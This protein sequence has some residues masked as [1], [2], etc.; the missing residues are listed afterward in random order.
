MM[1]CQRDLYPFDPVILSKAF[2]YVLKYF[3]TPQ[4]GAKAPQSKIRAMARFLSVW[5]NFDLFSKWLII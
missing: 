2:S 3:V 4:G 1:G 5:H